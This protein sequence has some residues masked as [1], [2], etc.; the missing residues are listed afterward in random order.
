[1]SQAVSAPS[2]PQ[3]IV[4]MG[5]S[6]SGK[7]VIAQGIADQLGWPFQEGDALHSAANVAKMSAGTPLTDADRWP[8]LDSIATWIRQQL[9]AGHSGVVSCS[10]LKRVY[11]ERL[12]QGGLSPDSADVRFLYLQVSREEL[13]RRMQA[14]QHFMPPS[15]LDSQLATLEEPA[16]DEPALT[17]PVHGDAASTV[18]KALQALGLAGR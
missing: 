3:V 2:R 8:W 15:L 5:T 1:M 9:Q 13:L 18:A 12:R 11:R 10:A 6:G 16:V 7:S 4:V 17:L 14:R